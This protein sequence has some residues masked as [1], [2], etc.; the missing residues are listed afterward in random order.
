MLFV[1]FTNCEQETQVFEI[2]PVGNNSG[3]AIISKFRKN[4][5]FDK[6][7]I[8]HLI[9]STTK[10]N[11]DNDSRFLIKFDFSEIPEGAKIDSAY[12][13]LFSNGTKHFGDN[14][15]RIYRIT[16]PWDA[17]TVTWSN[18]PEYN[19]YQKILGM[20]SKGKF[21]DY[22]IDMTYLV[23]NIVEN[24][25]ENHGFIFKLFNENLPQKAVRFYSSEHTNI[26]KHPKLTIYFRK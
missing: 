1:V 13:E 24:K 17:N 20:K 21:Q 7:E 16:E 11:E 25:I 4:S 12:L 8:L 15:F 18:Q 10:E 6:R 2:R 23:K 14:G 9:S 5:N 22:K 26:S 19:P 3:D